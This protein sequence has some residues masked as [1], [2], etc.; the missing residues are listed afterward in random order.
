MNYF[1][2]HVLPK[3]DEVAKSEDGGDPKL[4]L[5]KLLAELTLHCGALENADSKI[6][7]V[8]SCLIVR[9]GFIY[10]NLTFKYLLEISM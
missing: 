6:E 1:C 9:F 5:F 7:T 2:E 8:Y 10:I 4:E 3:I